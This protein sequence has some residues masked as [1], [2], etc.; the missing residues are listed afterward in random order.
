MV[1]VVVLVIVLAFIIM[2]VLGLFVF[3]A[4]LTVI[5][6][7]MAMRLSVCP[8]LLASICMR[9]TIS[10]MWIVLLAIISMG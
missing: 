9:G 7:I 8:V 4:M 10:V 6:V 3:N 2:I 1:L 5:S